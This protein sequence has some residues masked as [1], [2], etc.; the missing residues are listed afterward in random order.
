MKSAR[1]IMPSFGLSPPDSSEG[2]NLEPSWN[3]FDWPYE[4]NPTRKQIHHHSDRIFLD[5]YSYNTMDNLLQTN[6]LTERFKPDT[7]KVFDK[8]R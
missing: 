8:D 5:L 3:G 1:R 4:C 7:Y 2:T 6:G